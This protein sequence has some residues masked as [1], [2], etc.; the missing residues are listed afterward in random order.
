MSLCTLIDK[1]NANKERKKP[2]K[3]L[4]LLMQKDE[5]DLLPIWLRYHSYLFG[6]ENLIIIDNQSTNAH[7]LELLERAKGEGVRVLESTETVEKK[8]DLIGNLIHEYT[9][10]GNHDVFMPLDCDE[11]LGVQKE[12]RVLFDRNSILEELAVHRGHTGPLR[13]GGSFYNFPGPGDRFFFWDEA[14]VFFNAGS[15]EHID[16]GFHSGI[17]LSGQPEI[18]TNL[19]HVHYQHKPFELLLSHARQKLKG[20]VDV[21]DIEALRTYRGR[22]EHLTKYFSLSEEQYLNLFDAGAAVFLPDFM[23]RLQE[24]GLRPPFNN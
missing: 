11:F 22:G 16:Y 5:F 4:C 23:T 12:K 10:A 6:A 24:L 15:F 13:I 20:R 3:V 17:S 21:N 14:K 18:R 7:V 2:M 19:I 9:A 1:C 8:G